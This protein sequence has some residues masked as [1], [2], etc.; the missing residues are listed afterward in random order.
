[1]FYGYANIAANAH[2][3]ALGIMSFFFLIPVLTIVAS[4]LFWLPGYDAYEDYLSLRLM[5]L[6]ILGVIM[7]IAII[8]YVMFHISFF[9]F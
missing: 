5:L 2:S 4:V 8:N 9:L 1:M 7:L 3:S 6:N